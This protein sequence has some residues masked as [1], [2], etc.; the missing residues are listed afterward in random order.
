MWR[1]IEPERLLQCA[2][3]KELLES[4]TDHLA[5]CEDCLELLIFFQ[6]QIRYTASPEKKAA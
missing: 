1:H 2:Q 6:E 5:S 3:G 4:E